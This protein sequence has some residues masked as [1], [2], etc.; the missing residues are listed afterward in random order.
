MST[1]ANQIRQ[2]FP[3]LSVPMR[4][5]RLAYMD[6][7][8]TALKPRV[9]IEKISEYYSSYSANIHRGLYYLS[10][11]ATDEFEKV[12]SK[13]QAFIKAKSPEEI[14][15]TRGTTEGI[16]L[17]AYSL[18]KLLLKEGDEILLTEIEHH[19]N[20][21]PW[22]MACERHG[23]KVVGLKLKPNG[24]L[25]LSTLTHLLSSGKVKLASINYVS[26]ALGTINDV[27]LIIKACHQLNIPVV[28]DA[29][30]AAPHLPLDVQ[31][32]DCDFLALSAHKLYGPT[33]AGILYMKSSWAH[34]LPPFLGGGDMI[35]KVEL[36]HSTYAAPPA[37]FEAGTP[38][39]AEII[40]LGAAIDY[41]SAI[42]KEAM[43][44]EEFLLQETTAMLGQL[45]GINFYGTAANKVSIVSFTLDGIHPADIGTFLDREG[46][47]VRVGHHCTQP[48]MKALG[49]NSTVRASLSFYN[50]LEE[51]ERLVRALEKCRQFFL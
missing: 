14:V 43:A 4:G 51:S 33:G 35:D 10:E 26:N 24:E 17:L 27:K 50:T 8:A 15:F 30:Q 18:S 28:L 3:Q 13:A 47:A 48:L 6:S 45:K 39:V 46:I 19:S 21:V 41:Y 2:D 22:H 31:D 12:R 34:R 42:Q 16:N 32:L 5:H 44:H 49:V 25:D 7:G 36:D 1:W 40:G 29:A 11:R 20:L 38:P 9:V 23:A 37:R